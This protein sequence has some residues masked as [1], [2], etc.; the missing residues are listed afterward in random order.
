MRGGPLSRLGKLRADIHG[1]CRMLRHSLQLGQ[2]HAQANKAPQ[3][4][5]A[6]VWF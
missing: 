6:A 1:I 4:T 3:Q 2:I 5:S